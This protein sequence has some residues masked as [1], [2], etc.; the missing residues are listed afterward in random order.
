MLHVA[1]VFCDRRL[2]VL[3][4]A[5]GG[6]SGGPPRLGTERQH[7]LTWVWLTY[8]RLRPPDTHLD[9]LLFLQ[10]GAPQGIVL[11]QSLL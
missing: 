11:N 1:P 6:Q 8:G 4:A 5:V 3:T 9:G 10:G 7:R 2:E